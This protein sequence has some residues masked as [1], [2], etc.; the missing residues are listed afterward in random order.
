MQHGGD[1]YSNKIEYDFSVNMNPCDCSSIIDEIFKESRNKVSNYPDMDQRDFRNAIAEIEGVS[2]EEV[3]GTNGAS[4]AFMAIVKDIKPK[5]AMLIS[6]CFYG[7]EHALK[8]LD[9]CEIVT[10]KLS[11]ENSFT[12][13]D[14]F[15][16]AVIKEALGGK[17]DDKEKSPSRG[18]DMIFISNP[19]NPTGKLMDR[20]I[21]RK[22][23]AVCEEHSI[24]LV[25]DECFNK[26]AGNDPITPSPWFISQSENDPITPSPWF[27]SLYVVNAFTKLFSLPGIRVGYVV[28]SE[29]NIKSLKRHLPE[30]NM[31]ILAQESAG[32]CKDHIENKNW[33]E[34]TNELITTE[35]NYLKEELRKLGIKV[36]DSD[37][38]FLLVKISKEGIYESLIKEGILIRD[39]QN[40]EGLSKGYY[41]IA[42]KCHEENEVL[43]KALSNLLR[44]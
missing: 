23:I 17:T 42:V 16:D 13:G 28:S 24:K 33:L 22:L 32:V 18:L 10:Y 5:K 30:W 21:L 27:T 4:E 12:V 36:F 34:K 39:C 26:M 38:V 41:R 15:I 14:D 31:S 29:E 7:Y 11:E 43:I 20:T 44:G 2:S 35:R 6:P 37:T 9:D 40:F 3:L 1:I 19:N 25:I 8:S